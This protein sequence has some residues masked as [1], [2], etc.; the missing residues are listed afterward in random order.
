MKS[1]LPIKTIIDMLET[2]GDDDSHRIHRVVAALAN[3]PD[4]LAATVK[5]LNKQGMSKQYLTSRFI[6]PNVTHIMQTLADHPQTLKQ[7]LPLLEGPEYNGHRITSFATLYATLGKHPDSLLVA[8]QYMAGKG[9]KITLPS[10]HCETIERESLKQLMGYFRDDPEKFANLFTYLA[11]LSLKAQYHT[12]DAIS[13]YQQHPKHLVAILPAL[14]QMA[15]FSGFDDYFSGFDDRSLNTA[16]TTFKDQRDKV[17]LAVIDAFRKAGAAPAMHRT[18]EN[19][20]YYNDYTTIDLLLAN[21]KKQP[22][23]MVS[24]LKRIYTD[25]DQPLITYKAFERSPNN[26]TYK[27]NTIPYI[28]D[29][30]RDNPE[31][32]HAVFS[33]TNPVTK[34]LKTDNIAEALNGLKPS[35]LTIL[36]M[37]DTV[38]RLGIKLPADFLNHIFEYFSR[39]PEFIPLL[40]G[41][42]ERH[43]E[44]PIFAAHIKITS[45]EPDSLVPLFTNQPKTLEKAIILYHEVGA[46]KLSPGI[47]NRVIETF[48]QHPRQ[49]SSLI[50]TL[51]E[52][53]IKVPTT[54]AINRVMTYC[55][56][57]PRM[58]TGLIHQLMQGSVDHNPYII[59]YAIQYLHNKPASLSALFDLLKKEPYAIAPTTEHLDTAIKTDPQAILP[60]MQQHG[61]TATNAAI[62]TVIEAFN[63]YTINHV[64]A[65]IGTLCEMGAKPDASNLKG[66]TNFQTSQTLA[67]L[68]KLIEHGA[69]PIGLFNA[70]SRAYNSLKAEKIPKLILAAAAAMDCVTKD[71]PYYAPLSEIAIHGNLVLSE[72]HIT[73]LEDQHNLFKTQQTPEEVA[74][75][76]ERFGANPVTE[77][78][79]LFNA[80]HARDFKLYNEMRHQAGYTDSL[81]IKKEILATTSLND[82][83]AGIIAAYAKPTPHDFAS[84]LLQK[85]ALAAQNK[86]TGLT[87]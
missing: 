83:T 54:D 55:A 72:E 23:F 11:K 22:A 69:V 28:T 70:T 86:T 52:Q 53:K 51:L 87:P 75:A 41:I 79:T 81:A 33:T 45:I 4:G 20:T 26:Y 73:L 68:N 47:Y 3:D 62:K 24:L 14:V 31:T 35:P 36:P 37:M 64:P 21:F 38:K 58:M 49:L 66:V 9:S 42:R 56:D 78:I 25:N 19:A 29:R 60:V 39:S 71:S 74:T 40:N 57:D 76:V 48:S 80:E 18:V 77:F 17:L 1:S 67:I 65:I 34:A 46:P 10:G 44:N 82:D 13:I 2:E 61:V 12:N 50:N 30:L 32:L 7:I 27:E 84:I 59:R 85:R 63:K 43:Q 5:Y 16:I 8:L 15:C 6:S